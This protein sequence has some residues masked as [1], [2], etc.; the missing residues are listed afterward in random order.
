MGRACRPFHYLDHHI[1]LAD[2]LAFLV[3][4]RLATVLNG[5]GRIQRHISDKQKSVVFYW[6]TNKANNYRFNE[7]FSFTQN[8]IVENVDTIA[9]K[10][11]VK[12]VKSTGIVLQER[13]LQIHL[14]KIKVYY[15]WCYLMT[16]VVQ[17]FALW[18]L[19]EEIPVSIPGSTKF[20]KWTFI[21]SFRSWCSG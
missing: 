9:L 17:L 5:R 1:A 16:S 4:R 13:I 20:E 6:I 11:K 8:F 7:L 12:L 10:L 3:H 19:D 15:T 14:N 2:I 18:A 21:N